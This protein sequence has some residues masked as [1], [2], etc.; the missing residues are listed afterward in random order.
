MFRNIRKE[1][2]FMSSKK[3]THF[4][5]DDRILIHKLLIQGK[6]LRAIAR[7]LSCSASSVSREIYRN[8]KY[9]KMY[10][11]RKCKNRRI[12][13]K[14]SAVCRLCSDYEEDLCERTQNAPWVCE[15]CHKLK[16]CRLNRY[17]YY[18]EVAHDNYRNRLKE[19]RDDY[20]IDPHQ[21]EAIDELITPLIKEQKQSLNQIFA[22]NSEAIGVSISTLYRLI[23]DG[24][25]SVKN[26]DLPRRVRYHKERKG[27]KKEAKET[28]QREG[29][30]I[31]HFQEFVTK[32]KKAS[33]YEFDTVIGKRNGDHKAMLTILLRNSNFMFIFLLNRKTARAVVDQ[34]DSIYRKFGLADFKSMFYIGLTD[35]GSEMSD[36][37]GLEKGTNKTLRTHI[38]YCDPRASQQKG[39]L[40]RNHEYIRMYIPQGISFDNLADIDI[41]KMVNHINS[42]PRPQYENKTPFQMLS[43]RE[44]RIITKLGYREVSPEKVNLSPSLIG[45]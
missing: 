14:G 10:E 7:E 20:R 22:N 42:V 29:R 18:P 31:K 2:Y 26:I 8:R 32:H 39:K 40:E 45:R 12:C 30:T 36:A 27:K 28:K 44:K 38:F 13:K 34:F 16:Q 1:D 6:S 15:G 41:K 21:L 5:L 11:S 33:I 19:A 23:D 43:R 3:H 25:L 37:D 35:N 17:R 24:K 9:V 4:T